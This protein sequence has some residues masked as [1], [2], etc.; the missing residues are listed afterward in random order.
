MRRARRAA[1]GAALG[2]AL[3]GCAPAGPRDV[4]D[5]GH[6][7]VARPDEGYE[8]VVRTPHGVVALAESRGVPKDAAKRAVERLAQRFDACLADLEKKA[9]LA[10]GAARVI[11]PV[12]DGG[13]A[14]QP[15]V[16]VSDSGA[17]TT[18]TTVLCLVAPIRQLAFPPPGPAGDAGT[19]GLAIEASWPP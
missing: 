13:L 1:L 12:D 8:W 3:S 18:A 16:K 10:P 17:Q 9:P 14:L 15:L 2:A 4:S 5:R 19:R 11:V 7:V 6:D